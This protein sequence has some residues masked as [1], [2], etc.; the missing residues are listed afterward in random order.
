MNP[1]RRRPLALKLLTLVGTV[2]LL[3]AAAMLLPI[4]R[5]VR[6]QTIAALQAELRAIA[7]S[8][9]TALSPDDLR[10]VREHP[11][12]ASPAFLRLRQQL[13]AARDANALTQDNLYTL[14][15]DRDNVRFGVMTHDQ[16][17]PGEPLDWQ[18]HFRQ[19]FLEA[20]TSVS[21]LYADRYGQWIS[22]FAP[23]LD[24]ATGEVVGVIDVNKRARDYFAQDARLT[25]MLTLI[26][27]GAVLL[28]LVAGWIMVHHAL[29][30][31]V[32]N[33]RQG[34]LALKRQDFTHRTNL[35]SSDELADLAHLLNDL[36]AQL[37]AARTVAR[38]FL[39][40]A[41]PQASGWDIDAH[42][43][44]CDATAGDYFDV[45][46]LPDG[47]T[48]ILIAD[49]TGHGLGPSLH[50]A[51]CR[52]ALRALA[53]TG[54]PPAPLLA[55]VDQLLQDDLS[56][57][58]FITLFYGVLQP[59]GQLTYCNAGHGPALLRQAGTLLTLD[60]HRP[61]L[62]VPWEPLPDEPDHATLRLAP[63]DTLLLTT[64][65]VPEALSP[66]GHQLGTDLLHTTLANP[67]LTPA[68]IS[69]TLLA[70]VEAH[71]QGPSRTDDV[72][73]L[74]VQRITPPPTPA[75]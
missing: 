62:G 12:P 34:M 47:S 38:G 60:A 49:V 24:P 64:D 51:A 74:C 16:P 18:E 40:Q 3:T 1:P 11:D 27:A 53:S 71:C 63:G 57:G 69:H 26:A 25:D 48:A 30:R 35:R 29:L 67:H 39:P 21:P 46:T 73:V 61:P 33:L 10:A 22:A 45:F 68:Q 36:S 66:A 42:A 13:T 54:L 2:V 7:A 43:H 23:V 65:G 14:Y 8:V 31:P 37:N 56:G 55:R 41:I 20:R 6:A 59:D 9:A 15:L 17:F 5:E 19:P 75:P 4:R 28:S 52:T 70:A 58:R 72:T 50:M 32:G 44:S